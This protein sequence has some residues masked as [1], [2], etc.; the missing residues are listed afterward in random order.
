LYKTNFFNIKNKI[1]VKGKNC[2]G[3]SLEKV[4]AYGVEGIS[5]KA[6]EIPSYSLGLTQEFEGT[7]GGDVKGK[8]LAMIHTVIILHCCF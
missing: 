5:F 1:K 2:A 7:D 4:S 8:M 6:A 3:K